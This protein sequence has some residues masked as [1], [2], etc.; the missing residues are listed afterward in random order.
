MTKVGLVADA[1]PQAGRPAGMSVVRASFKR[2]LDICLCLCA[3]PLVLLLILICAPL[4]RRD[5]GPAFFGQTRVGRQGRIFTCWKLRTMA[6]DAEAQL[7]AHLAT[8]PR[9]RAEWASDRKLADDPRITP[10]GRFLRRSSLDELPQLWNVLRGDMSLV[11]PRPVVTEEL[12]RYGIYRHHYTALRPGLTGRWQ[13]SGRNGLSY[14]DRVALDAAYALDHSLI[15]DFVILVR[16][17]G[18]VIG[19]TGK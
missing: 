6:V 16:T 10:L 9:A 12:A 7:A 17:V 2:S 1:R 11:G 15:G 19:M 18:V 13:V 4:V 5:G 3:A 8:D 14:A